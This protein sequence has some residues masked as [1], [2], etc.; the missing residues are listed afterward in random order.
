MSSCNIEQ[1]TYSVS[2]KFLGSDEFIML[3]ND[4]EGGLYC[5]RNLV[6]VVILNSSLV[7]KQT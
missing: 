6:L 3:S 7:K 5:N 1:F 2:K 4:Q